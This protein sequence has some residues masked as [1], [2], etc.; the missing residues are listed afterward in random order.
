MM[1][2]V[3]NLCRVY[4]RPFVSAGITVGNLTEFQ[5]GEMVF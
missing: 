1:G 3:S 5:F 2:F 4:P